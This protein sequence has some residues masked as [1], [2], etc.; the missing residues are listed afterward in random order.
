MLNS[1]LVYFQAGGAAAR[2]RKR[3][4]ERLAAHFETWFNKARRSEQGANQTKAAER[5]YAGYR[6]EQNPQPEFD[7]DPI[8]AQG[9]ELENGIS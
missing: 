6:A 4:D 7:R 9:M 2:A 3:H 1:E 5:F 8:G